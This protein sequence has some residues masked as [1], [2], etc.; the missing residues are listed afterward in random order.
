MRGSGP[1]PQYELE[2]GAQLVSQQFAAGPDVASE[3]KPVLWRVKCGCYL[4]FFL[5]SFRAENPPT[6]A[7]SV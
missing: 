7:I 6:P 4:V 3:Q 1:N 5:T 2:P